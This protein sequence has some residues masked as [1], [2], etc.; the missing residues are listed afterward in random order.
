VSFLW[1]DARGDSAGLLRRN[2][3]QRPAAIPSIANRTD[4]MK[5]IDGYFPLYWESAPGRCS[6]KFRGSTPTCCSRSAFPPAR[7]ERHRLDRGQGGGGASCSFSA[8][9]RA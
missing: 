3:Q 4:G 8:S 7:V 1:I 5:K 2:S 9:G 6:W